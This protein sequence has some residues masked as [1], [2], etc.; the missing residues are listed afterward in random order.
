MEKAAYLGKKLLLQT[1]LCENPDFWKRLAGI[2]IR[3]LVP[4][5]NKNKNQSIKK[6]LSYLRIFTFPLSVHTVSSPLLI[7][8]AFTKSRVLWQI[9][10]W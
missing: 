4:T 3:S 10:A 1:H 6:I 8:T 7:I 5:E 9:L 2:L